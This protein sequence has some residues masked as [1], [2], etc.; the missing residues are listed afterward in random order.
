MAATASE[1]PKDN[2][3]RRSCSRCS[4]CF[5]AFLTFLFSTVG[6][7][8]LLIV[9]SIIGGLV[10]MQL[11][12][13]TENRTGFELE[14]LK[15]EI[16][17]YE[18]LSRLWEITL[19]MNVLHPDNWTAEADNILKNYTTVVY[20]YFKLL[21]WDLDGSE[22][23]TG[24]QWSFAGS[25]LYAI[26]VITTTGMQRVSLLVHCTYIQVAKIVDTRYCPLV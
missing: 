3:R 14:R 15:M 16:E 10:F 19:N 11:E 25:L 7:T 20:R 22:H 13:V 26:T 24:N 18:H 17:H 1:A 8:F 5:K 23:D 4:S 9:Y 6:L 21:R 2:Q 12:A